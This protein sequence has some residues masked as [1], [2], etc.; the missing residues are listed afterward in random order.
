MD[1]EA[2]E[3]FKNLAA[4]DSIF[5]AKATAKSK[6]KAVRAIESYISTTDRSTSAD[7]LIS[8]MESL[9]D[10]LEST[11]SP[12]SSGTSSSTAEEWCGD[13][14]NTDVETDG[15][16]IRLMAETMARM[17]LVLESLDVDPRALSASLLET[18]AN[19]KETDLVDGADLKSSTAGVQQ[20]LQQSLQHLQSV[21]LQS[22][23]ESHVESLLD[24]GDPGW[25]E[26]NTYLTAEEKIVAV[27]WIAALIYFVLLFCIGASFAWAL[28]CGTRTLE[29]V[30]PLFAAGGGRV[31]ETRAWAWARKQCHHKKKKSATASFRA[32]A[33]KSARRARKTTMTECAQAVA[34]L[35]EAKKVEAKRR[36]AEKKRKAEQME[37]EQQERAAAAAAKRAKDA[38]R[39]R[40][41]QVK[42][43]A[44]VAREA[45]QT[46][47]KR[48]QV[49][50]FYLPFTSFLCE[51]G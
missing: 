31:A 27:T 10:V 43:E 6:A 19:L 3:A 26:A 35:K 24:A 13:G 23:M 30:F 41:R 1:Q 20:S 51:S 4:V 28:A 16:Y 33:A 36:W 46:A 49:S 40:G 2:A 17:S 5:W 15:D 25:M 22:L 37:R 21:G 48:Y 14:A 18:M 12:T 32:A 44:R 45:K 39:L 29:I 50:L 8:A 38:E 11:T 34:Y 9:V 42:K 7:D 47:R